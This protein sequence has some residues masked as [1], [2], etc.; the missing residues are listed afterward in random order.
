[1]IVLLYI[2]IIPVIAL[3]AYVYYKDIDKEPK[4]LLKKV[5][6]W[7]MASIVPI[8]ILELLI[9]HFLPTDKSNLYRLFISVLIG[10]GLIEEGAKW[11]IVQ[12]SVYND[13]EFNHIYDAIVYSV[14]AS[15]GFALVENILYVFQ[16]G[17]MTGIV[18]AILTVPSHGCDAIIMGYFLGKAKQ[19]E[20]SGDQKASNKNLAYSLIMPV[21]AHTIYDFLL[22]TEN[23]LCIFILIVLLI[24]MYIKCFKL[25][26]KLSAIK[27]N[28]NGSLATD[29][30]TMVVNNDNFINIANSHKSYYYAISSTLVFVAV[31]L[32]LTI[33]I[34]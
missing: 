16:Y 23:A 20:F 26:R 21:L 22:F 5:F 32:F 17:F 4:S 11:F 31:I 34:V 13:K 27:V 14:F 29:P 9:G 33:L 25:I 19:A 7:G 15:L 28:F 10:V 30:K 6:L 2:A 18:R 1:M 24:I 8:V 12:K 3:C